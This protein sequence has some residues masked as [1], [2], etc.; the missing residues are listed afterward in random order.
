MFQKAQITLFLLSLVSI[1][2]ILRD[3]N[4]SPGTLLRTNASRFL[5][6]Q[7]ITNALC[8]GVDRQ[9]NVTDSERETAQGH[10][11]KYAKSRGG[12]P[13]VTFIEGPKPADQLGDEYGRPLFARAV[14]FMILF[15]I[16]LGSCFYFTTVWCCLNVSW[17]RNLK[18]CKGPK[19]GGYRVVFTI[20]TIVLMTGLA[21]SALIGAVNAGG[22]KKDGNKIMCAVG[23]FAEKLLEGSVS[24]DW[25]GAEQMVT[26]FQ[27]VLNDF[28]PMVTK[29]T[30]AP[31]LTAT[32]TASG[33][34]V[35]LPAAKLAAE[36]FS[37]LNSPKVVKPRPDPLKTQVSYKPTYVSVKKFFIRIVN[38]FIEYYSSKR[39]HKGRDG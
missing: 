6:D 14:P 35:T 26:D 38:P 24:E 32:T 15:I 17:C 2:Y 31:S 39:R 33:M 3:S 25:V 9:D 11:E 4:S 5:S 13:L 34:G 1:V 18:I 21:I 16:T 7:K 10:Q 37:T 36:S 19:P 30:A 8:D 29:L 22:I 28:Y 27:V 23:V 20:V 12:N